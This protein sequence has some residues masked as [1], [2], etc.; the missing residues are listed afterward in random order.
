MRTK[1][2]FFTG[3][4]AEYGLLKPLMEKIKED[5]DLQLQII[6]S[7][8]HLSPEFGLTYQE[9]EKDG[10]KID[11]KVEMLLSSDTDIGVSKSIGLGIIG[12]TDALQRLKPDIAVVLGDRFEALAFAIASYT[13]RIPIAHLYGG[14]ATYGL[15][16]EGFRHAIT[17][18]SHLHFTST[19]EY[20]K[21]V[22][23]LGEDPSRVFN[24]GALG[25]DNIKKMKLLTKEEVEERL[26]KKFKSK[27]LL[28]TFHPVTLEKGTAE[29]HFRELL[30]VLDELDDTLLIFTKANADTE[31]RV[32]NKMIDEYANINP[33]K[34]VVF[35]NM[36][37]LL[38][39]ST[40]QYVDAV[41]GN[42]SSGIIEAPSFKIGTIDIGDRQ[43]G[44]IKAK[45]VIDCQPDYYSIKEAI[46][47]LYSREFKEILENI[48]NPYGDGQAS[49]KIIDVL[50]KVRLNDL[51]KVFY[52]ID[53][54]LE[55]DGK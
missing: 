35:T 26:G 39:L 34:V 3:T 8:M 19:E 55:D 12:Y 20:R 50:K 51:K 41:V 29:L 28:I 15:Y 25:I 44:R 37:Q 46:K 5:K 4:R 1:I 52:Y 2:C 6:A 48:K 43:K 32:I 17:K 33:D 42:S 23:Q 16:D 54:T 13:L 31:G 22:I 40:M 53:I 7:G 47:K 24:A 38:Y 36:G 18:L 45:S 27:N 10:F 9:I 21:R 11:E 30:K 49:E 14:E